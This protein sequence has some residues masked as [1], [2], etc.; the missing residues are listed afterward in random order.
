MTW[1]GQNCLVVSYQ[2]LLLSTLLL[3]MALCSWAHDPLDVWHERESGSSLNLFGVTYGAGKF[4]AVGSSGSILISSNG[5]DWSLISWNPWPIWWDFWSVSYGAG[6]FVAV[7]DEG[8]IYTSADG[9]DW[10]FRGL[11]V[12][13]LRCVRWVQD[14]FIAT[15]SSGRL[16]LSTNGTDWTM[17]NIGSSAFHEARGI[18]Y[19][20]GKYVILGG[21]PVNRTGTGFCS[22]DA[23]SWTNASEDLPLPTDL[24]FHR[25][26]FVAPV[27]GGKVLVSSNGWDWFLTNGM[28][29]PDNFAITHVHDRFVMVGSERLSDSQRVASSANGFAW[30]D[31]PV[32]VSHTGAMRAVTV[33]NNTVVVVGQSGLIFQSDPLFRLEPAAV[34]A[35]GERQWILR[36]EAGFNY[37]I[38]ST[39]DLSGPWADVTNVLSTND[40]MSFVDPTPPSPTNRFYRVVTP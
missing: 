28:G 32:N 24:V 18:A 4:V 12:G 10:T 20:M 25:D 30:K 16:A 37:R 14:R 34:L 19:G 29:T 6:L 2:K 38:Q 13:A 5:A 26:R 1:A 39:P 15:G 40:S 3:L 7:G 35:G 22:A 31:H 9:V 33:G 11:P 36:G 27:L 8:N 17:Q 23:V 21:F